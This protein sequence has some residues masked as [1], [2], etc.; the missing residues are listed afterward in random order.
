M[1]KVKINQ[2]TA[3]MLSRNSKEYIKSF[4]AND[5]AFNFMNTIKGTLSCTDLS[6]NELV[7]I[8]S[9]LNGITLS[10]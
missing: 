9:K 1:Q 5:E 3:G 10:A 2:L 7:S 8:I 6:W 4:V